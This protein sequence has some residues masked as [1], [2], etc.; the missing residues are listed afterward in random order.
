VE[1]ALCP[2]ER[3]D[4]FVEKFGPVEDEIDHWHAQKHFRPIGLQDNSSRAILWLI[5]RLNNPILNPMPDRFVTASRLSHGR[6]IKKP[7]S[8]RTRLEKKCVCCFL[9]KFGLVLNGLLHGV[10]LNLEI[11]TIRFFK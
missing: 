7:E 10:S 8:L 5:N 4:G 6:Q 1:P 3:L 2:P 9:L 11:L